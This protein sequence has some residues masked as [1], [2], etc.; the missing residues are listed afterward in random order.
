MLSVSFWSSATHRRT[1]IALLTRIVVARGGEHH[2]AGRRRRCRRIFHVVPGLR[3]PL[4][5]VR[6]PGDRAH[7]T[8]IGRRGDVKRPFEFPSMFYVLKDTAL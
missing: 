1:W 6:A 2:H 5:L 3:T 7:V 4:G 8:V